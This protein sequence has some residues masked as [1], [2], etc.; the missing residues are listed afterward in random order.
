LSDWVPCLSH[1]GLQVMHQCTHLCESRI[2]TSS[3]IA[4][5]VPQGL[6]SRYCGYQ[7]PLSRD[8]EAEEITERHT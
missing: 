4:P 5:V 6:V 2:K 3:D 7:Q 1:S 8:L